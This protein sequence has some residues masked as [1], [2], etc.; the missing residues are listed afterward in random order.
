[1]AGPRPGRLP[2]PAV[3]AARRPVHLLLPIVDLGQQAAFNPAGAE[4]WFSYLLVAAGWVLA[5]TIAAG[6]ARVI[7][8]R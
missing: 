3:R 1:M 8:R 2:A 5:T 7:S 6:I 4:Q